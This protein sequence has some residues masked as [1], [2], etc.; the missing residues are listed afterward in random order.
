MNHH[1]PP[2]FGD[3]LNVSATQS[4]TLLGHAGGKMWKRFLLDKEPLVGILG[5]SSLRL[6]QLRR[7]CTLLWNKTLLEDT[8]VGHLWDRWRRTPLE[9][10]FAGCLHE[11]LLQETAANTFISRWDIAQQPYIFSSGSKTNIRF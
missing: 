3:T 5:R 6:S 4:D 10:S 7:S 11:T 2:Y 8:L 1:E 9:N